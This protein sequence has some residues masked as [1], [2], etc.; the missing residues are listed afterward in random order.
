MKNQ[1][2][3]CVRP[4]AWIQKVHVS[5]HGK[6]QRR[7]AVFTHKWMVQDEVPYATPDSEQMSL[8]SSRNH[9]PLHMMYSDQV[10]NF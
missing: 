8:P 6:N 7:L 1:F 3:E 9:V 4:C 5:G 2:L 10:E